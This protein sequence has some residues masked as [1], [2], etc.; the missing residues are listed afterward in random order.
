[1]RQ[2]TIGGLMFTTLSSARLVLSRHMA[3]RLAEELIVPWEKHFPR[4]DTWV[5]KEL[6]KP[7]L[8]VRLDMVK[9]PD[10]SYGFY[11]VEERP[12]GIGIA[13]LI[14][15]EFQTRARDMFIAWRGFYRPIAFVVSESRCGKCDDLVL[16]ET[17]GL[18]V[19]TGMPKRNGN[20]LYFVR[21][22]PDEVE[23]HALSEHS[24][25]TISTE[26]DKSY[27]V[28]LGLWKPIP[29][30]HDALPWTDGFA[31]KPRQGSKMKHVYLWH[32]SRVK[33]IES[34]NKIKRVIDEGKVAYYQEWLPP[35]RYSLFQEDHFLV[36]RVY[37]GWDPRSTRWQCLGGLWNS[38]PNHRIHGAT[39]SVFGE[40]VL[41]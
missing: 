7:S 24:V 9:R 3:T 10:G 13:S 32:P 41:S 23:F 28:P 25:S 8:L 39:D 27:G 35:E 37:W 21:A 2:V 4:E 26:G 1:M 36:R 19:I 16:K 5:Q 14:S 34:K 33:G 38:R 6:G 22:E 12:M 18:T 40:I 31:L 29:Q 20:T 15:H 17:L 11:E 30:N